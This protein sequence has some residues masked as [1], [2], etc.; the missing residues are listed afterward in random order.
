[1]NSH[2]FPAILRHAA[3][4]NRPF[5]ETPEGR[6]VTYE[7]MVTGTAQLAA[8]LLAAD[9]KP[10]DRVVVQVEKSPEAILLYLACWRAGAVYVPLNTAYTIRELEYFIADARPTL[11]VCRP[12]SQDAIRLLCSKLQVR[13][14]ETLNEAGGGSLMELAAGQRREFADIERGPDDLA[15]L[16]YTSG[17]TGRSKGAMLSHKNLASNAAALVE[18]WRFDSQDVLLHALPIFHT[19]GLF[20]ATNVTLL[21]GARMLFMAKFDADQVLHLLP[22]ATVLMGVPTFYVRLLDTPGL[23]P[24]ACAH[25]RLFISGSAPLLAETHRAWKAKTGHAILERYGLTE[26]GMNTSN[27]YDGERIAGSVGIPL[28]GVEIRITNQQNGAICSADE[29]GMIEVRGPNVFKG[30]WRNP[31]KTQEEFRKDAFFIT[32]DLGKIDARGYLRIVGRSKDLI[33]TGGYNVYPKEVEI[34]IDALP[35]VFE[36]AVIGLAHPDF[37]EAVTAVVVTDGESSLSEAEVLKSLAGRLASYKRPKR[38]LF[39]RELP[40]NSMGKVEKNE[41]R[42]RYERLYGP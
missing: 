37:G 35:G 36:S 6:V 4:P 5:L 34:E 14:C 27:P 8:A 12:Q 19:H 20:V 21:A 11:V 42:K 26:T 40:R 3:E 32:G 2:L 33:I 7:D 10:G 23:T 18:M 9:I 17:T 29:I 1:M 24:E 28:P 16:L 30:Y 39:E 31:Q 38:V 25:M 22:R 13:V 41:L 15:A